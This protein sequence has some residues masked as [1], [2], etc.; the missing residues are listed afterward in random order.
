MKYRLI[1]S[2]VD[3]TLVNENE[4]VTEENLRAISHLQQKGIYFA[5]STGRMMKCVQLLA[6]YYGI[7]SYKVCS[8][9]AIVADE[10]GKVLQAIPIPRDVAQ[11]L[12]EIGEELHCIMGYNTM[13]EIVY[14]H[15]NRMEDSMYRRSDYL[16]DG[17][18]R[19]TGEHYV[20]ILLQKG[21]Q[22]PDQYGDSYKIAL[23]ADS[24]EQ[25]DQLA[26]KIKSI[27]GICVTSAMKWH[28]EITSE[29]VS[30]WSGIQF[31]MH[32]LQLDR[33]EVVCIGDSMND[34]A[35]VVGAG[36]GIGMGNGNPELLKKADYITR[37]NRE[38]GV[39]YAIEKCLRGEL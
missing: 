10:S 5:I 24:Q 19:Q 2:D 30:K 29:N 3:G 16:Y 11:K 34:E 18:N 21:Y 7:P 33:E 26:E 20:R 15:I 36:M 12:Y 6:Q 22:V 23:W 1:C 14:N 9:G 38:S 17:Y 32:H 39:A 35:M 28:F 31:L 4:Q 25:Y 8:N 13:S 37:S 27:Q